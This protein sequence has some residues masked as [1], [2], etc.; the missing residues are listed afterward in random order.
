MRPDISSGGIP[1]YW[2]V[3]EMTGIRMSG[4]MSVGMPARIGVPKR[5]RAPNNGSSSAS[6]MNVYGR[7]SATLTIHMSGI[8]GQIREFGR[9]SIIY[10]VERYLIRGRPLSGR[11]V[12]AFQDGL[13][14]LFRADRS[15]RAACSEVDGARR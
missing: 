5:T 6:T 4:K 15:A 12:D 14:P 2:N 7:R 11:R 10:Q 8:S 1:A 13:A 9:L 3:I